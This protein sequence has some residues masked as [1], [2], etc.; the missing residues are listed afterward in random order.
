[1]SIRAL[2]PLVASFLLPRTACIHVVGCDA[3]ARRRAGSACTSCQPSSTSLPIGIYR[4]F[5]CSSSW[6]RYF[7]CTRG[8]SPR[9]CANA[10]TR[11]LPEEVSAAGPPRCDLRSGHNSP[12]KRGYGHFRRFEHISRCGFPALLLQ[13]PLMPDWAARHTVR[14]RP[15]H[16]WA[17]RHISQG[18]ILSKPQSITAVAGDAA[19]VSGV[20]KSEQIVQRASERR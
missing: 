6:E 19:H 5:V 11:V 8:S 14:A 17:A 4:H 9:R 2:R 1:M 3:P 12:L 20:C 13:Q 18:T 10:D 15:T 16:D 7:V